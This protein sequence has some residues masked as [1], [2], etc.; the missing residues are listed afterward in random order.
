M[1]INEFINKILNKLTSVSASDK[2]FFTKH[3]SVMV[4]AGIPLSK[5]IHTLSLQTG[6]KKF[7]RILSYIHS[8]LEKGETLSSSLSKH[9]DIFGD[10]FINMIKSGEVSGQLEEVFT[11]L[12]I[13][14]KKNHELV[15]KIRNAL[16]YPVII[17]CAMIGIGIFTIIVVIPKII[18][19]FSE[20]NAQL[21]IATRILIAVSNAVNNHGLIV[22]ISSIAAIIIIIKIMRTKKGKYLFDIAILKI[23]VISAIVKKVNLAL[24]SRTISSLLKTDIS[25]VEGFRITANV[26]KNSVYKG[27]LM[28]IA[29][30]VKKGVSIT[31]AISRYDNIFP[32]MVKQM[33]SIGEESGSLDDILMEVAEFYEEEVSETMNT[34][35]SIIEPMLMLLLGAGVTFMAMAIIMPMYSLTQQF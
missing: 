9:Q 29:E 28:E 31:N 24:F 4:K 15:M 32:A 35:P 8:D 3:M 34:L 13:Q 25:I 7:A 26:M 27:N 18:D 16:I 6:N 19:I 21:P 11:Q 30:E 10:L 23:P 17:V 20:V 2:M 5:G 14:L 33:I 1:S 22:G 12:F